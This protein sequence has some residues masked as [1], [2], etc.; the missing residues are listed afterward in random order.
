MLVRSSVQFFFLANASAEVRL[1][2]KSCDERICATCS[3]LTGT[4]VIIVLLVVVVVSWSWLVLS[5]YHTVVLPS[6]LIMSVR[7]LRFYKQL[8]AV[9]WRTD[10]CSFWHVVVDLLSGVRRMVNRCR[11]DNLAVVCCYC[12]AGAVQL[13]H[14]CN[15]GNIDLLGECYQMLITYYSPVVALRS[16]KVTLPSFLNVS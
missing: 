7:L 4:T 9:S 2:L 13:S 10:C 12:E 15:Y 5:L 1:G 11:W 14:I 16:L 8:L 6:G 3:S